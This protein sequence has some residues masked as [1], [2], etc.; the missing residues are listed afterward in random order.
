MVK[1]S[2][3]QVYFYWLLIFGDSRGKGDAAQP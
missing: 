2:R 3:I 1:K